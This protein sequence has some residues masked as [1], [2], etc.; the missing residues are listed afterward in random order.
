MVFL[1][2]LGMLVS[3]GCIVWIMNGR[4]MKVSVRVIFRGV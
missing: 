1:I 2:F 4:V 3:I